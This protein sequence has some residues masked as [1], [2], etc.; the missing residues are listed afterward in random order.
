MPKSSS[1]NLLLEPYKQYFYIKLKNPPKGNISFSFVA[2]LQ[3]NNV[4][5]AI[6]FNCDDKI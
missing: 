5:S 6:N 1:H 3:T 2:A 4:T